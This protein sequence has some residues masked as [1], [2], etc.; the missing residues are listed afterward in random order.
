MEQR[1]QIGV[2]SRWEAE[3]GWRVLGLCCKKLEFE[4]T[5]MVM[6][7]ETF[8]LATISLRSDYGQGP[9]S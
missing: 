8:K 1:E 5:L 2:P 9:H 6:W 7:C 4:K 3:G